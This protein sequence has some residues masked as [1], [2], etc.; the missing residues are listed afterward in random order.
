ME[1]LAASESLERIPAIGHRDLS[2]LAS[3][4]DVGI[5]W[6][7]RYKATREKT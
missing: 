7:Q 4:F 6:K 5:D 3:F 1:E 2:N